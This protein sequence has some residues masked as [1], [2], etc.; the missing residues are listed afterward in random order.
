MG[1]S[2]L[3]VFAASTYRMF[4]YPFIVGGIGIITGY[5]QAKFQNAERIQDQAYLKFFRKYELESLLFGKRRTLRKYNEAI[6]GEHGMDNAILDF[7]K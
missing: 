2:L 3:Y 1:S 6:I 4:E 5:L 7:Y